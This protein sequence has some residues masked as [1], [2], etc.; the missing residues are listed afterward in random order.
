MSIQ[1]KTLAALIAIT[2]GASFGAS[3]G[4]KYEPPKKKNPDPC[5][6]SGKG[7]IKNDDGN[8]AVDKSTVND[9][10]V[11]QITK[12][13]TKDFL[14]NWDN[15]VRIKVKQNVANQGNFTYQGGKTGDTT[16]VSVAAAEADSYAGNAAAM[17]QQSTNLGLG[18]GLGLGIGTGTG[19]GVGVGGPS[20]ALG[21]GILGLGLA[22]SDGG[23]GTGVGVGVG[24]GQGNGLGAGF[25][26]LKPDQHLDQYAA[27]S[28]WSK[29]YSVSMIKSGD[30]HVGNTAATHG[31][32]VQQGISGQSALGNQSVNVNSSLQF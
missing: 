12:T 10:D 28:A 2:V 19:V 29:A 27:S 26:V 6:E 15:S 7:V 18:L 21:I 24:V 32:N 22:F 3:A 1:K 20:G 30:N 5:C 11:K 25:A 31:I 23:D 4:Y 8:Q 17:N 14:N 9:I 13:I 16:S